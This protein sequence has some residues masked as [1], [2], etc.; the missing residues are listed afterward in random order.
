MS[1]GYAGAK[2]MLWF[3]AK[4]HRQ[5]SPSRSRGR[6]YLFRGLISLIDWGMDELAQRINRTGVTAD[7]SSHLMWRAVANQAISD[8]RRD[9]EPI[10]LIG[11]SMGADS[12][13]AFAEYL[14]AADV[15]VNLL[16]TYEPTR[17]ADDVPPNVE[18]SAIC[19][20][21]KARRAR[22][23]RRG[24]ANEDR[25]NEAGGAREGNEGAGNVS[26]A[27]EKA[28]DVVFFS[29]GL[30][31]A[32]FMEQ[33]RSLPSWSGPRRREPERLIVVSKPSRNC[34]SKAR[35]ICLLREPFGLPPG[36]AM[37]KVD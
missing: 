28:R 7:I 31:M 12:A 5:R 3:M 13:V 14:N 17:F 20:Q 15:P 23:P 29:P 32:S 34:P 8:Y 2:R 24:G 18:S 33:A 26:I 22:T 36:F 30:T 11:H 21:L 4:T 16:V 10:T 9:P 19:R 27:R 6:A 35:S 37:G 25:R 1:G